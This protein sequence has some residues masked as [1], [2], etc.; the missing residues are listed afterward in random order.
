MKLSQLRNIVAIVDH[1]SLRA[2]A[3]HLG[4]AQPN[5]TRSVRDLEHELGVSLFERKSGGMQ[6]T[7][8][9]EVFFRRAKAVQ[10]EIE[11]SRDEINQLKGQMTGKVSVGLSMAS[12][13]AL[14]PH[15]LK[16]LSA[17]FPGV[18]LKITEGF[19]PELRDVV[20]DGELDFYVGPMLEVQ[21][22]RELSIEVLIKSDLVA[23]G[24]KGHPLRAA[25]SLADLETARWVSTGIS[26]SGEAEPA[27][28]FAVRGLP[29]PHIDIESQSTVSTIIMVA[30][31]DLL[32]MVPRV[33]MRYTD[34]LLDCIDVGKVTA[35]PFCLVRR[36][37][38]PL[39]P[40]AEFLSDMVRRAALAEQKR[41][42]EM[43]LGSRQAEKKLGDSVLS[44]IGKAS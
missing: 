7:A 22:T 1:R 6:L 32:A 43:K 36:A 40:A 23:V 14:L 25:T 41:D 20:L 24:R 9:G 4:L 15:L 33:C 27:N 28:A 13:V 10:A 35:P 39:T 16:P 30:N 44:L 38:L 34:T 2:A 37:A 18:K 21:Q 19:F 12:S 5:L 31:T 29:A 17:R 42:R 26:A 3:Q 11:R 8:M